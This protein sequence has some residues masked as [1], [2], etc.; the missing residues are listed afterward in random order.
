MFPFMCGGQYLI[1]YYLRF[2][3]PGSRTDYLSRVIMTQVAT[4]EEQQEWVKLLRPLVLERWE[5]DNVKY[6]E[7]IQKKIEEHRAAAIRSRNSNYSDLHYNLYWAHKYE[8]QADML[9][10]QLKS[11]NFSTH[12]PELNGYRE[13]D[14]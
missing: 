5:K 2:P 11:G 14:R 7:E 6:L 13:K 9:E 10:Q 4:P 1:E 12:I 8:L 3:K